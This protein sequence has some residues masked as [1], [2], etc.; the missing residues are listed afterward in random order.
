MSSERSPLPVSVAY[1]L[2]E[3]AEAWRAYCT[4]IVAGVSPIHQE[5]INGYG[6]DWY[7]VA[8]VWP[9]EAGYTPQQILWFSPHPDDMGFAGAVT[10]RC[11]VQQ[12]DVVSELLFTLG[13]TGRESRGFSNDETFSTVRLAEAIMEAREIGIHQVGVITLPDGKRGFDEWFWDADTP[14]LRQVWIS[15]MRQLNPHVIYSPHPDIEVDKHPDHHAVALAAAWAAGRGTE[16]EF[17]QQT[18]PGNTTNFREWWQYATWTGSKT[19]PITDRVEFD[20]NGPLA[21]MK[22]RALDWHVSQ[23]GDLYAQIGIG[24]NTYQGGM[25][26]VGDNKVPG[27]EVFNVVGQT[28]VTQV[29][30]KASPNSQ[31]KSTI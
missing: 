10:M 27:A 25:P 26:N 16:N 17:Y 21:E 23:R 13:S 18:I 7:P 6:I 4:E 28:F 5:L 22:K 1:N 31:T 30:W 15:L 11:H 9:A 24:Y 29:E 19:L 20:L 14:Y 12:G 8:N 3:Q 2:P